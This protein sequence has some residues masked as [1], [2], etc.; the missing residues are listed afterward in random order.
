MDIRFKLE[1]KAI[2]EGFDWFAV[3][4]AEPLFT[5]MERFQDWLSAEYHGDMAWLERDPQ[6]RANPEIVLEDAKSVVILGMNYLR[7]PLEEELSSTSQS[8]LLG[9]GKVSKYARTRDYHRVIE[10]RLRKLCR[11]LREKVPGS[12]SRAYVD[13][14]PILER[15]WAAKAGLGFIG[16][17]TMLI[18]P[19]QGSFFFLSAIL[20]TVELEES[21][22]PDKMT[23]CGDCKKCLD[24]CP[25][26]AIT[27]PFQVDA[28]R[29]L[30]YLTIEKDG[31]VN[32][33]FAENYEGWIFGCDI[34]QDVCP[35]NKKRSQPIQ[36]SPLGELLV[37]GSIPL[38]ELIENAS[39]FLD[40]I[41]EVATPLR[42]A[43]AEN[44]TR[45]A[46]IV[47]A[48][49]GDRET[50][51][52]VRKLIEDDQRPKWLRDLARWAEE[53]LTE[54]LNRDVTK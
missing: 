9:F 51:S 34:C 22:E 10:K 47:A 20:T 15:A 25:T 37:P 2:D 24:A 43:G 30:S 4:R 19:E 44:L 1:T 8:N 17:N 36:D 49:R 28:R 18:H 39:A 6:R 23:G 42:R 32:L 35:Y 52:A 45:N 54:N 16:K 40:A 7:F 41:G 11:F 46:L 21:P 27:N 3:A 31:P 38:K 12:E 13:Y 50:L 14:G 33:E 5:D 48:Y 29:C 26:G 53:K